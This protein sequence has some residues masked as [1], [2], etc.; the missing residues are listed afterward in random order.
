MALS[1]HDS[2]E[3]GLTETVQ[4]LASGAQVVMLND[5][6]LTPTSSTPIDIRHRRGGL[7]DGLRPRELEV[8][9]LMAA[10]ARNQVL[11][12]AL[13]LSLNTVR[14]HVQNI[15]ISWAHTPSSRRWRPP[16]ERD[17]SSSTITAQAN[18]LG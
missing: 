2:E 3:A 7:G 4:A 16:S 8:L 5:R 14:N 18:S 12:A 10:G 1:V 9:R 13:H 6:P 15:L 17:S 11:A